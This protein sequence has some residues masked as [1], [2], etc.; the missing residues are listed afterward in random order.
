MCKLNGTSFECDSANAAATTTAI[1]RWPYQRY[2]I[3]ASGPYKLDVAIV[4]TGGAA[5]SVRASPFELVI[6][7]AA[8]SARHST[9]SAST[10]PSPTP[11]TVPTVHACVSH[12]RVLSIS[13]QPTLFFS[14]ARG[15]LHG[16]YCTAGGPLV[17]TAGESGELSVAARD[18]FGNVVRS[19]DARLEYSLEGSALVSTRLK[20]EHYGAT[21]SR[22]RLLPRCPRPTESSGAF[23]A[24]DSRLPCRACRVILRQGAFSCMHVPFMSA[25]RRG[26][27]VQSFGAVPRRRAKPMHGWQG[28]VV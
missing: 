23:H 20:P 13:N 26:R 22:V 2:N 25:R 19:G 10:L 11:P 28:T 8:V 18:A 7:P 27:F 1:P 17:L 4:P 14:A 9:I 16:G 5:Q 21:Q 15:R 12:S 6:R 3:T 24:V